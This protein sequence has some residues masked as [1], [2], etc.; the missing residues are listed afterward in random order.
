LWLPGAA[1]SLSSPLN[2]GDGDA[3]AVDSSSSSSELE[4]ETVDVDAEEEPEESLL[5]SPSL[6]GAALPLSDDD[7]ALGADES[8]PA[9]SATR[10]SPSPSSSSAEEKTDAD[11]DAIFPLSGPFRGLALALSPAELSLSPTGTT[12]LLIEW[13]TRRKDD[14]SGETE[15]E[16]KKNGR[17]SEFLNF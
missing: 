14:L 7:R 8:E 4:E 17:E 5:L 13:G 9:T 10:P 16:G 3:P 15:R 11:E 1:S 2:S 12:E 6:L